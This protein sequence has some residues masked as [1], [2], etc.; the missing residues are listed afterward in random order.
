MQSNMI[1]VS[2]NEYERMLNLLKYQAKF[3]IKNFN[4]D[5]LAETEESSIEFLLMLNDLQ[6]TCDEY[7]SVKDKYTLTDETKQCITE[8]ES[9]KT[10]IE[11]FV[12]SNWDVDSLF[13]DKWAHQGRC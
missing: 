11:E 4:I 10:Q 8:I 1:T 2:Q 13:V 5:K 9:L 3:I 6:L 7:L 12:N